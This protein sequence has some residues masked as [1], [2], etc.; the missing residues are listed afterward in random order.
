MFNRY[1]GVFSS[2]VSCLK[3]SLAHHLYFEEDFRSWAILIVSAL[4]S[5]LAT[6]IV[7]GLVGL[8]VYPGFPHSPF[9]LRL[10]ARL[11]S[12]LLYISYERGNSWGRVIALLSIIET[13]RFK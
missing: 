6:L 7:G 9:E 2:V 8:V 4:C 12:Y 10:Q 3:R 1:Y 5:S 13:V 11:A